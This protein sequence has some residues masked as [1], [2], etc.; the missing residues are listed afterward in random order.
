MPV[1]KVQM[2]PVDIIG[3]RVLLTALLGA[4]LLMA[5]CSS[6]DAA[7]EYVEQPVQVLYNKALADLNSE[8]YLEAARGFDEVERQHPYSVWSTK[9]QLMS[10]FAYY[11]SNKYDQA[12]LAADRFIELHPGNK[13]VPYAH[14]LIAISYYEQ[15][16]GV[17]R[18]QKVTRQALEALQ[19]VVRRFPNTEYARDA[20]LKIDLTRDHLAGKEMEIGR[21]Y[22]KSDQYVAAINRFRQVIERYQ[23][24]THVPEALHRLTESYLALGIEDEAK[25]AAAVLGYNFPGSEWYQDSYALLDENYLRPEIKEDSWMTKV[26]KSIF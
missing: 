17:G 14:Y 15:I 12:I 10:A 2:V 1:W 22:Q 18:D 25:N 16:S 11:Q 13:D 5:G 19:R 21:Y 24:T 7:P 3:K 23:T 9:A 4:S 20:K 26:W 6:D 8:N